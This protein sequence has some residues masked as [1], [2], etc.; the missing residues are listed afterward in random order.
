MVTDGMGK[1]LSWRG[2]ELTTTTREELS[3]VLFR[4]HIYRMCTV[5]EIV[6]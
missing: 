2:G 6:N 5:K 3:P 4:L 1:L